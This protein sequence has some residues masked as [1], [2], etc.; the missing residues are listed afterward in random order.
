MVQAWVG[1]TAVL[2][3]SRRCLR[4]VSVASVVEVHLKREVCDCELMLLTDGLRA[5]MFV[6]LG[7]ASPGWRW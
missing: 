6:I 2:L 1:V 4:V 7:M 5:S 3:S